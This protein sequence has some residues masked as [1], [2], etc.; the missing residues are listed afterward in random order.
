M[1]SDGRNKVLSAACP[2]VQ[3][4]LSSAREEMSLPVALSEAVYALAALDVFY[5][6][7]DPVH[8]MFWSERRKDETAEVVNRISRTCNSQLVCPSPQPILSA[9]HRPPLIHSRVAWNGISEYLFILAGLHGPTS[10][11]LYEAK[12]WYPILN[13]P[14]AASPPRVPNLRKRKPQQAGLR[15]SPAS[16][17]D[18]EGVDEDEPPAKR[19]KTKRTSNSKK[20][21]RSKDMGDPAVNESSTPISPAISSIP[22]LP[23]DL[24]DVSVLVGDLETFVEE[25]LPYATSARLLKHK[26]AQMSP[27][28]DPSLPSASPAISAPAFVSSPSHSRNRST[29]QVSSETSSQTVVD[30][31]RSASVSSALTTV[32]V[33]AV[34]KEAILESKCDPTVD[35]IFDADGKLESESGMV[36]RG[37]A[38][39]ARTTMEKVSD[40]QALEGSTRSRPRGRAKRSAK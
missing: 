26:A 14:K 32:E 35:D 12:Y 1:W 33:P 6:I 13:P 16:G 24:E 10:S 27:I 37:R 3:A 23:K 21:R 36:T 22:L 17:I 8:W 5:K 19:S 4:F 15:E 30:E 34:G 18:Q 29:S 7:D 9:V 25:P 39:K 2:D 28:I 20:S 40:H 31:R 11:P 38:S